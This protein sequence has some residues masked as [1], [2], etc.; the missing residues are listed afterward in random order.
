[1]SASVIPAVWKG[2]TAHQVAVALGVA[3]PG[4]DF[5]GCS[6]SDLATVWAR[7]T[8]RQRA[9]VARRLAEIV[10]VRRRAR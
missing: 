1:M 6:K 5:R 3:L 8:E 7:M 2:K 10:H 9:V 4:N